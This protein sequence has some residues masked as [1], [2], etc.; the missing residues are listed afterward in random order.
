[1]LLA[2]SH[3][4]VSVTVLNKQLEE[5][6]QTIRISEDG[7]GLRRRGGCRG[8]N[9]EEPLRVAS[10]QPQVHAVGDG[11]EEPRVEYLRRA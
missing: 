4:R 5:P 10:R 8:E 7:R 3:L 6:R 1:M 9:I 11:G 2:P